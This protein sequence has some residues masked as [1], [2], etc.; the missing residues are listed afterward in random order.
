MVKFVI[1]TDNGKIF[2]SQILCIL[3]FFSLLMNVRGLRY[4]EKTLAFK[5]SFLEKSSNWKSIEY[6]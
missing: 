5:F 6:G 1:N 2:S 3:G 4:F